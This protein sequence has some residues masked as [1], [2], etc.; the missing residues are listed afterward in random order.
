[1][2]KRQH[3]LLREASRQVER[4]K[5]PR[6]GFWTAIFTILY[7]AYTYFNSGYLDG[8]IDERLGFITEPMLVIATILSG[9]MKLAGVLLDKG[10]LKQIGI[11]AMSFV[12]GILFSLSFIWSVGEGYPAQTFILYG[13]IL[14][15]CLNIAHK[16]DFK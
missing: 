7:G 1:M 5:F 9:G 13:Y 2:D 8:L 16:G 10:T 6:Y 3:K 14:V 4:N 11:I 12:W 15:N